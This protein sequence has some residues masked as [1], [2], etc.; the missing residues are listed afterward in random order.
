MYEKL[1]HLSS[2]TSNRLVEGVEIK[3]VSDISYTKPC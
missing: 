3:S 1:K 2:Y